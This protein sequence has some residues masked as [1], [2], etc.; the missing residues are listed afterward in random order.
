MTQI[1]QS[2]LAIEVVEM[3]NR[4]NLEGKIRGLVN[5]FVGLESIPG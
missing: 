5:I 4:Q 2:F 3:L 1:E